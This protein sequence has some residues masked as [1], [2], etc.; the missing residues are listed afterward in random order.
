MRLRL[1][2]IKLKKNICIGECNGGPNDYQQ[3]QIIELELK[4]D[5]Q[6]NILKQVVEYLKVEKCYCETETD[7]TGAGYSDVQPCQ[8]CL[9]LSDIE[10]LE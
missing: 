6:N 10:E 5:Q 2:L 4:I 3:E 1:N 7:P 8:R 9:I